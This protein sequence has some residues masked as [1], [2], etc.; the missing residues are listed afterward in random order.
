MLALLA[1]GFYHLALSVLESFR[2]ELEES[3]YMQV[4][5]EVRYV[6]AETLSMTG[7]K[8]EKNKVECVAGIWNP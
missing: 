1:D 4:S 6:V 3:N 5:E 2:E 7:A 8:P